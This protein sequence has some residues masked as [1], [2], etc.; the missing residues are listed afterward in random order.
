LTLA[1]YGYNEVKERVLGFLIND[2]GAMGAP[3]KAPTGEMIET[4]LE[5]ISRIDFCI[6]YKT[7]HFAPIAGAFIGKGR[8]K[9]RVLEK[10]DTVEIIFSGRNPKYFRIGSDLPPVI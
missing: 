1:L 9:K 4:P 2:L 8:F 7:A 5:R 6:D 10:N 3:R